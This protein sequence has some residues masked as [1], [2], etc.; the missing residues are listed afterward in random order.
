M[1][2]NETAPKSGSI[3]A[4]EELEKAIFNHQAE[5]EV[6]DKFNAVA[7]SGIAPHLLHVPFAPNF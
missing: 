7:A 2:M 6:I 4:F 5:E 3:K 1:N